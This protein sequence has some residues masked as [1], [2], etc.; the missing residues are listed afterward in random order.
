MLKKK[1]DLIEYYDFADMFYSSFF[2]TGFLQNKKR[3]SYK[4]IVSKKTP[5]LLYDL[6]LDNKW[7]EILFSICLFK[8]KLND[9]CF[10]FCIDT[11]DSA[12]T[13]SG[14]GYHLPLLKAVKY[15]F[16]VNYNKEIIKTDQN[17]KIYSD[18]IISI[19]LFFPV[20][21]TNISLFFPRITSCEISGWNI[22]S[23]WRRIA[24][25]R[26]LL[27]LEDMLQLRRVKKD[28]DIFF[29]VRYYGDNH[30]TD[31]EFRYQ[32]MK[33]LKACYGINAVVGFSSNKALP[34]KFNE[35]RVNE[36]SLKVYM[37]NLARA[38]IGI[39][40]RGLHNCLSFKLGQLLALGKPIVGQ[41][42]FNNKDEFYNNQYF[43]NQFAFNNP[44]G[45]VQGAIE[46]LK[47]RATM[48]K[49]SES[50]AKIFDAKFT[51]QI[52]VSDMLKSLAV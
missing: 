16:K 36:Y 14:M 42:I 29:V 25:L 11:R 13:Q 41:T 40:T 28:L 24:A 15:Y 48:K 22:N 32:I 51:P 37:R 43:S 20:K 26:H 35:F 31:D 23:I 50:N 6:A 46:L 18:K 1:N 12:G 39:Y 17:L 2:L 4:F 5:S 45:I 8:A 27:N 19:P 3:F 38:K 21:T 44:N 49:I 9:S 30:F 33:K 7:K 52:I 10:Y 47:D 34:G